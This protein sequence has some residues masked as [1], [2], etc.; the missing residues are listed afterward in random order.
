MTIG[1]MLYVLGALVALGV[2]IAVLGWLLRYIAIGA[3]IAVGFYAVRW[4]T[5][6]VG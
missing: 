4:L 5:E 3:A 6:N 1:D 2:A